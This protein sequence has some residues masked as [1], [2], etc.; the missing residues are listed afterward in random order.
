M[1]IRDSDDIVDKFNILKVWIKK[2]GIKWIINDRKYV[3]GD[4]E[5]MVLFINGEI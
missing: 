3:G 2:I 4:E 1:I 5:K